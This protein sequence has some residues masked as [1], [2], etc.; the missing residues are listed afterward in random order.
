MNEND[1][2]SMN[3]LELHALAEEIRTKLQFG[4]CNTKQRNSL[5]KQL[6]TIE[7]QIDERYL[8]C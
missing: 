5:V 6:Q 2:M 8:D 7:T 4:D 1:Y 3:I